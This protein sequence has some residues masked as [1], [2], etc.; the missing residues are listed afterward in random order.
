MSCRRTFPEKPTVAQLHNQFLNFYTTH[1]FITIS[2]TA[3]LTPSH[4]IP[5]AHL[6][7]FC[8]HIYSSLNNITITAHTFS[9]IQTT[10]WHTKMSDKRSE[11]LTNH[12]NPNLIYKSAN[13]HKQHPMKLQLQT[14]PNLS[15]TTHIQFKQPNI[16]L[17]GQWN[18]Q[19]PRYAACIKLAQP[20][21]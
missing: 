5:L 2:T 10:C 18:K 7:I 15:Q 13:W 11:T 9:A 3:W 17:V 4:L 6:P 21:H 1:Q 20:K 16:K 8:S 19:P 14:S 12:G